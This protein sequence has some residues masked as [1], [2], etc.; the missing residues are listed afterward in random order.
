MNGAFQNSINDTGVWSTVG[1]SAGV[2]A[3]PLNPSLGNV[4]AFTGLGSLR[5]RAGTYMRKKTPIVTTGPVASMSAR[6]MATCSR[7]SSPT[8]RFQSRLRSVSGRSHFLSVPQRR[9]R[10][11][12]T[13]IGNEHD[14]QRQ[15][16]LNL[17]LQNVAGRG[18]SASRS[19]PGRR[20]HEPYRYRRRPGWPRRKRQTP[21]SRARTAPGVSEF[22]ARLS[23]AINP[24]HGPFP[25]GCLFPPLSRSHTVLGY[26][27][28]QNLS[29][30]S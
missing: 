4:F 9:C 6:P 11:G 21:A 28:L 26:A 24:A 3:D 12:G 17:D 5:Q 25:H 19:R 8:R 7:R 13:G 1:Y 22:T 16:P 30:L 10:D 2:E 23:T 29:T 15:R 20:Y 18:R 27:V 14:R